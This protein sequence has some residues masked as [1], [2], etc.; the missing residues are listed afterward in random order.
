MQRFMA[1]PESPDRNRAATP[2]SRPPDGLTLAGHCWIRLRVAR[3]LGISTGRVAAH[4][5]LLRIA[6]PVCLEE[7]YPALQFDDAGVRPDVAMVGVLARR[8]VGDDEVCDWL[9]RP[10][11]RLGGTPPLRWMD[12]GG[13]M[14]PLLEALPEP[15]LPFPGSG[16]DDAGDEVAAWLRRDGMKGGRGPEWWA[17]YRARGGGPDAG[18]AVRDLLDSLASRRSSVAE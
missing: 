11:P 3:H 13:S 4:P 18:P 10:N 2:R 15:T 14:E 9:V 12:S 7:A 8:R 6:A 1:D 5:H 17:E 16:R